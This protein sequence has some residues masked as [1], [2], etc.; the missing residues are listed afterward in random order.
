MNYFKFRGQNCSFKSLEVKIDIWESSR[1]CTLF[2]HLQYQIDHHPCK[3]LTN[4]SYCYG[5]LPPQKKDKSFCNQEETH[6]LSLFSF[7]FFLAEFCLFSLAFNLFGINELF[8][9]ANICHHFL[10]H[11]L[12]SFDLLM[13]PSLHHCRYKWL[14][15]KPPKNQQTFGAT[16]RTKAKPPDHQSTPYR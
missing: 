10:A 1:V 6:S 8:F 16:Q 7:S 2:A 9:L 11:F 3:S 15:P 5:P 14:R 4:T 13:P 12:A